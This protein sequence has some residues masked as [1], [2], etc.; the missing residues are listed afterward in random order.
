VQEIQHWEGLTL[1]HQIE[2]GN[3]NEVWAGTIG[4]LPVAVRRSRRSHESLRWEL[5]LLAQLSIRGFRVPLPVAATDG[6]WS[7]EGVVVQH[8]LT[9]E[10]PSSD[11]DWELAAAELQRLHSSCADIAQRPGCVA[12]PELSARSKSVDADLAA[13]PRDVAE[14]VLDVFASFA[15]VPTSLIHGDPMGSNIRITTD[16]EVGLLDWDESRVDLVWHD[17][18]NLGVRVLDE[19]A[20]GRALRLSDAWEA[21]NAWTCEPSYA[22]MRLANLRP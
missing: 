15:D 7:H 6:S 11:G 22:Q 17:L 19:E 8:W 2:E 9:G 12:V 14:L 10:P 20:H 4:D 18:S 1:A 13:V 5:D 21:V 3:R 16:G